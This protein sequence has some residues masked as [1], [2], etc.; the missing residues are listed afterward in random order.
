MTIPTGPSKLGMHLVAIPA[1][2]SLII[3]LGYSSQWLFHTAS[4]LEPGPLSTT[5]SV[6][7]NTLLGCLWLSYFRACITNPGRYVFDNP[8]ASDEESK[9][10]PKSTTAPTQSSEA[11]NAPERP[12]SSS[13]SGSS[14][15]SPTAGVRWCRKCDAPKPARSHHCRHCRRCI[16][17]MD[18]HCPWTGN[19]VSMQTFPHF[20]RFVVFTNLS[21]WMAAYLI[22][23]RFYF[24]YAQRHLP[25]YLGPTLSQLIHLTI[26]GL[27]CAGTT[28]A[29]S[30]MLYTTLH[31]WMF[32]A[33]M[34]EGWEIERHEAVVDRYSS[35]NADGS[36][37]D[38]DDE[39]DGDEDEDEHDAYVGNDN[40]TED[41]NGDD[42]DRTARRER[43]ARKAAALR[44]RVEFPYD[45]GI[46]NNMAQA[47]GTRNFLLWFVPFASG[48]KI[49][50]GRGAAGAGWDWPENGFNE[51][52]GMWP[53]PDPEKLRH[54]A[55]QG[56]W[57]ATGTG[58]PNYGASMSTAFASGRDDGIRQWGTPEEE[59]AAFHARQEADFR[60]RRTQIT[61]P[62]RQVGSDDE[63]EQGMDG[64]PGWTNADGDRLRDYGVDEEAENDEDVPIATLL[65]RRDAKAKI[66]AVAAQSKKKR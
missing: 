42:E 19:C 12:G 38:D 66:A 49:A 30:I 23:R 16:P 5:E 9:T 8:G 25:A 63:F 14:S 53:P 22:G 58:G 32:N 17:K 18:H 1:A 60:R 10:A 7:F 40:K 39:E 61:G 52:T 65:Q 33:T 55:A 21:L 44:M 28:L 48:P 34:I 3:F 47:M 57:A 56:N 62:V 51:R 45:L 46:F 4:S 50:T 54:A 59:K 6:V 15:H 13:S 26:L 31:S 35:T 2:V 29:L 64:E 11:A 41:G 20:L 24:L 43:N 27:V 36:W 37:W